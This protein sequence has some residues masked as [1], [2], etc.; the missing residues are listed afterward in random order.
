MIYSSCPRLNFFLIY[1]QTQWAFLKIVDSML[2]KEGRLD[3][4]VYNKDTDFIQIA[5]SCRSETKSAI[6]ENRYQ[7][8]RA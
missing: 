5:I 2:D 7:C 8:I 4:C 6:K 1:S 3:L